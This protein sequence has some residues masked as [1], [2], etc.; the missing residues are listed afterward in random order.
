MQTPTRKTF[1]K[2][3]QRAANV[4]TANTLIT[5]LEGGALGLLGIGIP[6]IPIFIGMLMKTLREIGLSFGID[7][8]ASQ[9]RLYALLLICAALT[10]NEER[11]RF[12]HQIL[13]FEK[14]LETQAPLNMDLEDQIRKT[15]AVLSQVLLTAKFVQG[16]PVVG[17]VG[18]AVNYF[19]TKRV[20]NFARLKYKKRYLMSKAVK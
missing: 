3:Q 4:E 11:R 8:D 18:G 9:E 14:R 1:K 5:T 10:E 6:D 17:V 15:A 16:L 2:V 20:A 13:L 12:N 7:T 19:V